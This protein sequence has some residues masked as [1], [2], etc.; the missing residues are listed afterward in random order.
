V[1]LSKPAAVLECAQ[2]RASDHISGRRF[3]VDIDL[4]WISVRIEKI[5]TSLDD[6][7]LVMF[8]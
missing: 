7:V 4:R 6:L 5:G 1:R 2:K 3:V 8:P